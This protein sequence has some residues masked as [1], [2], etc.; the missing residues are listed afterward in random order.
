MSP[1]GRPDDLVER[2][3]RLLDAA[4]ELLLRNGY[5]RT[6]IDDVAKAAGVAKGTVYRHWRSREQ[7]FL[8]LL[9]RESAALLAEVREGLLA[10][11]GPTG[12]RQLFTATVGAYLR[13]PLLT[14]VLMRD[15]AVLG[16]LARTAEQQGTA[17]GSIVDYLEALRAGGWIRTDRTLAEQVTQL[18][19]VFL[20]YFLT[21]PMMPAQFRVPDPSVPA[22]LADTIHGALVRPEPLSAAEIAAVDGA[23]RAYIT[24]AVDAAVP[25]L[26]EPPPSGEDTR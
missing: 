13:R 21:A 16:G 17:R 23:T 8:A 25:G 26:R 24:A 11:A 18:S 20:G 12:P 19:A 22:L 5:D 6:T 9:H 2:A 1:R 7:M 14:A 15:V 10:T 3:G 4:A